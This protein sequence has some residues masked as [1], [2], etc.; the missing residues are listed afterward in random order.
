MPQPYIDF[1]FVKEHA[2][3]ERV[4]E[5]YGLTIVGRGAQRAVLCPFHRETKPS[6]KVHL[7]KRVFHCFGCG[8]AGNVLDFVAKLEDVDLR[9]AAL[10]IAEICDISTAPPRGRAGKSTLKPED[11]QER[12]GTAKPSSARQ[13]RT[14][15]A[16]ASTDE[17]INP[18]LTFTLKLDPNHPYFPER[19]L[20]AEEASLFGL[21]YCSRG[22]MAGRIC[23]PIHDHRGR[24]VAYAGRWPGDD[25]IPEGED[26]Y[27]LPA[28]FHKSGVLYNLHRVV[29]AEHV[30]LVEGYWSAIQLHIL[31]IP[32]AALM[33]WAVSPEQIT[34][35]RA[36][37]T[38]FVTLLLDGDETGRRARDK[39]LP[40]LASVFFVRAPLLS[41]GEKPDTLDEAE[42]LELIHFP[43][44]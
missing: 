44:A 20:S 8:E 36:R 9:V 12:S 29:D 35:L 32:T 43:N 21:G 41:E 31:G 18:P 16:P 10:K 40:E 30:V 17:P 25:D 4:L 15:R 27:K 13:S 22:S 1:A 38:R 3:F 11:K 42:L 5:H 34:L 14:R 19:G 37:R 28:K 23:I 2:S 24:L 26:R 39:V 33:G 7:E 6:C